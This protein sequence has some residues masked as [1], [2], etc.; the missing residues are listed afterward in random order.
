M[1]SGVEL[2][3]HVD[4]QAS[5]EE[6]EG[7][8][9]V[10]STADASRLGITPEFVMAWLTLEVDSALDGVGLTAAVAT[11]LAENGLSCNV[12]AAFHH[13]H[14]LVSFDEQDRAIEVLESLARRA[15]WP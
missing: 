3:G 12:L 8:T 15:N 7:T 10:I 5:I 2:P 6:R 1:V 4:V 9:S 13:D 14:L 11:A